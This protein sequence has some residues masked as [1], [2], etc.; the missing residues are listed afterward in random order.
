MLRQ[1]GPYVPLPKLPPPPAK[2]MAGPTPWSSESGL[3][4]P[5]AQFCAC[6]SVQALPYDAALN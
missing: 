5:C 4:Q 2:E 6:Q 3:V 1:D